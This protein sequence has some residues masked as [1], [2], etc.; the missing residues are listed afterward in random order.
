MNKTIL[1]NFAI[2][3]RR[4]LI[5]D[6]KLKL[7]LIGITENGKI[8]PFIGSSEV[9][10]F[11]I[12][13]PNPLL[14]V[15]EEVKKYKLLEKELETRAKNSDYKTAYNS[16]V[17]EVAYT[18]FN[19]L[20]A[21]RFM[22]VNEYL[23]DNI[24]VLTSTKPGVKEPDLVSK[25]FD[26]TID[27]TESEI[28]EY[29]NLLLAGDNKSREK[30]FRKLFIK[31]CNDL[32]KY[33]PEL[34]EKTDDYMELL[35]NI[36][37]ANPDSVL[38]RLIEDIPE[39]Y[40]DISSED[41]N[42]QVEII[43]W[44]Y[45]YYN[46]EPKGEVV[47]LYS[48]KEILKE[49]IPFATQIFTTDWVVRYM[50][51]NSLGKYWLERNPKSPIKSKLKY[52]LP[53]EIEFINEYINPTDLKILDNA[54]GS[55]HILVYVFDILMDIYKSQGYLES[56]AAKNIVENNLFGLD[57]DKRAYQLSYFAIMM[58]AREYNKNAFEEIQ[59][60]HI[61]VFRDSTDIERSH[62]ENFGLNMDRER[63]ELAL[64][65]L[66]Y[67]LE[68]FENIEEIGSIVNLEKID[69]EILKEFIG[70]YNT[71]AQI[72]FDEFNM[73]QTVKRLVEILEIINLI[74]SK[75]DIVVTN[76]PYMNKYSPKLKSYI[77]KYYNDYKWDLFSVF[78]YKNI[79]MLKP[80]GYSAYMTPN[81]WMFLVSYEKLRKYL[82]DNKHIDTLIHIS[83]GAFY[84]EATVDIMT[85][86]IKN[87]NTSGNGKYIRLD[88]FR[89][90][91]EVQRIK[92]LEAINNPDCGYYYI[93]NQHNF[94][95][96]PTSPISYWASDNIIKAFESGKPM[97]KIVEPKQGLATANN[98]RFLRLWWET[99]INKI[100]FNSDSIESSVESGA[101]WFPY[102][103]GGQRRQWYGNY[104]YV[105]N[106]ENDGFEIRNFKDAN[107][108]LRSRP[109]NTDYY[110]RES[111]TWSDITSGK[112]A[113]RYREPGSIHDVSG[114]SAFSNYHKTIS[115]VLGL[116]STKIS[117]YLF[118]FINPTIHLQIG[119]FMNFPVLNSENPNI[120]KLVES[121]IEISKDEWNDWEFAW[122]FKT[123]PLLKNREDD[124]ESSYNSWKNFANSQFELL[125]ENEEELNKI[126]IELYGLEEELTPE[127]SDRDITITKIFDTKEEI[128]E[129]IKGNV[130]IKTRED[131]IKSFISYGVGCIFGR[132][133]LD[134]DG[135]VYAG[136]E[137][138]LD[139]YKNLK[140]IEDGILA[141]TDRPYLE[142]DI[143]EKFCEFV[144]ICFGEENLEKNLNFIADSLGEKG[145]SREIIR[146]YFI[147]NFFNDH[148]KTYSVTGSGRRPIYWLYDSGV[149]NGFKALIYVHRYDE[150]TSGKVRV[151]NL[152]RLQKIYESKMAE[153]DY[154]KSITDDN[155]DIAKFDKEIERIYKQLDETREYDNKLGLIANMRIG[156]DLDD[157]VVFNYEKIQTDESGKN[158]NILA[159]R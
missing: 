103:K 82:I 32:N 72:H 74:V 16:L 75:Y 156:I 84:S 146:E 114:M 95:K 117:N 53:G 7:E 28:E 78:I 151:D 42:G 67:I 123:H 46:T 148:K 134:E 3:S 58:K 88:D 90:D 5:S 159:K 60:I 158:Y 141:I 112:F 154:S 120:N 23:P 106:W 68:E 108:K 81:V 124:L 80:K 135:L 128:Y 26:S 130:Y 139:R 113:I 59:N 4:K 8:I 18:W 89:G 30:L 131:V 83:K 93:T 153:L 73:K 102:N 50:V 48:N 19:R 6:T 145:S 100:S 57:I 137:W 150:D 96:I 122:D 22:E 125:K 15:G 132:Y 17:E 64:N 136:G 13:T 110:F 142:N 35:L 118:K 87:E 86:I 37:F 25:Y 54:M 79:N 97:G 70:D 77:E 56:E 94:E 51:D 2:E 20:I 63:R 140:P 65:Q 49:E 92:T 34:F 121:S 101:K 31:Q 149:N 105:V 45:Q 9:Y 147:K 127:V 157:G 98:N 152:H 12:G 91:M 129:D 47:G 61:K 33:L 85:F 62:L 39:E 1:R 10:L 24:K 109:Q 21:I 144:E 111:I 38:Y 143:V 41:G 55:G 71:K 119:N 126:F 104:D 27:L 36:S 44:L 76:P 11:D 115:Y 66:K 99:D 155:R 14:L 29:T 69:I 40:F 52:L 133:S 116:M 43:G 107:G 138:N